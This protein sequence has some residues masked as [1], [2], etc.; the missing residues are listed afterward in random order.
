M[1]FGILTLFERE[2]WIKRTRWN[3]RAE[4]QSDW[5][6]RVDPCFITGFR[7]SVI[8]GRYP[9]GQNKTIDG[10]VGDSPHRTRDGRKR[11]ATSA[12]GLWKEGLTETKVR[13]PSEKPSETMERR[14]WFNERKERFPCFRCGRTCL[15]GGDMRDIS[16]PFCSAERTR[17]FFNEGDTGTEGYRCV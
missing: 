2:F 1:C 16:C 13:N 3:S 12:V 14:V 5:P 10:R 9:I 11:N 8:P 17:H 15:R 4:F 6:S 7:H